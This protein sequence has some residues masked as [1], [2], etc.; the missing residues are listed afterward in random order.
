MIK[1]TIEIDIAEHVDILYASEQIA[2]HIRIGL[3][4]ID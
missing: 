4:K 2:K 1:M 3:S